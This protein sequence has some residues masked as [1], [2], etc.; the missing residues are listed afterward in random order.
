MQRSAITF[1]TGGEP[2]GMVVGDFNLD[3]RPD[4][5]VSNSEDNTVSVLL[6]KSVT[7]TL[8]STSLAFGSQT[9]GSTSAAQTVTLTNSGSAD[10]CRSAASA[11]RA[12]TPINTAKPITVP[13]TLASGSELHDQRHVLSDT[14]HHGDR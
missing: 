13:R 12:L 8:S 2:I 10:L 4:L 7:V 3:G 14:H 6:A 9:V 11:L 5:A 1:A